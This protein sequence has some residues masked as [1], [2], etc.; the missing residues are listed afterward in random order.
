MFE[1]GEFY[2]SDDDTDRWFVLMNQR[3]KM[4]TFH[5]ARGYGYL[6]AI[7]KDG[8]NSVRLYNDNLLI[9][10]GPSVSPT[11]RIGK[12]GPWPKEFVFRLLE[13]EL[14]ISHI[15][16]EFHSII[17]LDRTFYRNLPAKERQD[18]QK[19]QAD[20][21]MI[22]AREKDLPYGFSKIIN[23]YLCAHEWRPV[24]Y[25]GHNDK[26]NWA[27]EIES[28]FHKECAHCG[29]RAEIEPTR[30]HYRNGVKHRCPNQCIQ[31]KSHYC[32]QHD[33]NS[34]RQKRERKQERSEKTLTT[35]K[36]RIAA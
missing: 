18:L 2:H 31:G 16:R 36:A 6:R 12:N 7:M 23:R 26:Y 29:E 20:A 13:S 34:Q 9:A 17:W 24:M 22:V 5:G 14:Q 1:I 10:D 4:L 35:K 19:R 11:N 30:C 8:E 21:C 32:F 3:A 25:T 28:K 15:L 27:F 33:N